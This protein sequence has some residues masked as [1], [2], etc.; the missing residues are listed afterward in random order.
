MRST[1]SAYALAYGGSQATWLLAIGFGI[2]AAFGT[3]LA[4]AILPRPSRRLHDSL[5]VGRHSS[6]LRG[7]A[8][9]SSARAALL[10]LGAAALAIGWISFRARGPRPH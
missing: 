2:L 4:R 6:F 10:V 5:A 9:Y 7:S 1:C 3:M 8:G